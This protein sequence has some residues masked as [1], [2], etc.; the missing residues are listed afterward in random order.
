MNGLR[1]VV[2]GAGM[3][4]LCMGALLAR[5]GIRSFT[6]LEKSSHLGGTWWDNTYPGAQCD[7]RSHLYAF[8]FAPNPD[9][10]RVFAPQAEILAYM[11][12]VADRWSLRD[13]MRFDTELAAAQFDDSRGCWAIR[14]AR[15]DA[16]EADVPVCSTGP[17]SEPRWPDIP[18]LASFGGRLMHTA[19]WDHVFDVS[20]KSIAVIGTA[21]SA[22]QVVPA[23]APRVR[24]LH[25]FQRTPNWI[26]PRPDRAYRSWEKALSR[27]PPFGRLR[28]WYQYRLHERNRLGFDQGTRMAQLAQAFA[29]RHLRKPIADPDPG[30]IPD[31]AS[32]C[33]SARGRP[34]AAA[35]PRSPSACA[36]QPHQPHRSVGPSRSRRIAL[37]SKKRRWF[38]ASQRPIRLLR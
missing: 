35:A 20:G 15:G 31:L 34:H 7:V 38:T 24:Q 21:A 8:S 22:V 32:I 9:W 36:L 17:L 2:L 37:I 25:V 23:I 27:M 33:A 4:G 29:Q 5:A 19:R 12:R 18:G 30:L 11:E 16:L 1:I 6:I 3:S 10:S 26:V 13:H 28:R 14:T